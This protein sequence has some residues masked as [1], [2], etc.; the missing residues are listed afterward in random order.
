MNNERATGRR[1]P[2]KLHKFARISLGK[3]W[4]GRV[5]SIDPASTPISIDD[6][7][8]ALA[9]LDALLDVPQKILK[10]DGSTT[11]AVYDLVISGKIV[12]VVIKS[13]LAQPGLKGFFRRV[14][15]DKALRNFRTA[16]RLCDNGIPVVYPFAALKLKLGIFTTRSI[17]ITEYSEDSSDLHAFIA[18]NISKSESRSEETVEIKKQLASQIAAIFAGLDSGRLWHRDAKAGNFLVTGVSEVAQGRADELKISLVDMDG[19][20]PYFVRTSKKRFQCLAK[21]GSTLTWHGSIN[22]TDYLRSFMIYCN[23]TSMDRCKCR[24]VFRRISRMAIAIRL[25]TLARSAM[26]NRNTNESRV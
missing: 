1:R 10:S 8:G 6:W 23:L 18:A 12:S 14:F 3:G 7:A 26:N 20:K 21:L 15:R 9:D 13:H 4:T 22:L 2:S 16:V 17:Y 11:V 25:I 24:I 19:I 5:S